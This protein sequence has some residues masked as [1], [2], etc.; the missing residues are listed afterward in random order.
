VKKPKAS[1]AAARKG[2]RDQRRADQLGG[3]IGPEAIPDTIVMQV[4]Y[5]GSTCVG[6]LYARGRQG[7]EAFDADLK[8]LGIFKTQQAAA[9]AVS[10]AAGGGS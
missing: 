4:V 1:P 8:T 10:R 9:G 3:V 6:F 7:V 5:D 2:A